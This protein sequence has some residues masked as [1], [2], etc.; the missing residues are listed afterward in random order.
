MFEVKYAT[1][2]DKPFWFTLDKHLSESEFALKV[3]DRR[4]YI[5]SDGGKPIGIMRYN[6]FW[7]NTP[8]LTLI[9]ITES[10][11]RQG[12]G[13]QAMLHWEDEMRTLGY[14]MVMTST[15][16]DEQAQHFYR[17]LGYVDKGCLV[18]DGTPFEQPP[19][20]IMIKVL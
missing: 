17:K 9:Y 15:Q 12:F 4:G 14:K 11:Q 7:D 18:L 19:E 16:A 5:I 13:R 1:E 20:I 2:N 10:C 6:L 8:F 3:R